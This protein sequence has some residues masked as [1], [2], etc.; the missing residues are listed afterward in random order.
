[1]HSPKT[2][3]HEGHESRWGP[4]FPELRLHFEAAREAAEP[5]SEYVVNRY[6]S[7]TQNLRTQLHRIIRRA[8]LTPWPK[9]FQNL[10]STRETE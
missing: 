6:R 1:V 8:G 5:D 9:P 4:L 2:K 7:A 3:R 10:R